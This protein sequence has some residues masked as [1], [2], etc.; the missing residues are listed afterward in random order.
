MQ[1]VAKR[2]ILVFPYLT[3]ANLS[4]QPRGPTALRRD[5]TIVLRRRAIFLAYCFKHVTGVFVAAPW[6]ALGC[7]PNNGERQGRKRELC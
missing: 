2:F 7:G 1:R 6:N 3:A 5:D 4:Y